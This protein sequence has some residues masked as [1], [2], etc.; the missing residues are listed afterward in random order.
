MDLIDGANYR[1][2][3]PSNRL[4][5]AG[6]IIIAITAVLAGLNIWSTRADAIAHSRQEMISLGIVLA[7]QTARSFQAVDL[8]LQ[9]TRGMV[10]AA[11]VAT[12]DQFRRLMATEEVHEYLVARLHSLP[13]ADAVTLIDDAGRIVNFSRGWPAPVLETAD[14][15]FYSYLREHDDPA[16]F[17]GLPVR[18]RVTGAWVITLTRRISGPGGEFL[19][20]VLSIIEARYFEE[21]Y[22]AITP[23]EQRSV[24]LFHRDGTVLARHPNLDAL[25]GEKISPKSPWY[26]SVA[27]GGGTYRTSSRDIGGVARIVSVQPVRE[28][29]LVIT[30]GISQETALADWRSYSVVIVIGAL[31]MAAGFA[32]LFGALARQSRR[33][34]GRTA[35][36][37]QTA[38]ALR[39]S[40]AR[41]RDYALT[42]SDWFWE[43]DEQHRFTYL[44][45]GIR[46]FGHDP[47]SLIGRSR[48]EFAADAGSDSVKWQAHFAM[49]NRHEPFRDF[50]YTRKIDGNTEYTGSVSGKPFFDA[51]GQFLGY[52]GSARDISREV[53]AERR[54]QEAKAAAESANL[55]K[56]QFLA[57][58]SHEL[59]TPLNA[60]VG[61]SEM[62]ERGLAGPLQPRQL[63]YAGLIHQSGEHLHDVINDILDLAKVDAGKLELHEEE[64]VDARRLIDDCVALLRVRADAAHVKLSVQID[65]LLPALVVD[66]TRLKQ[67]LLNLLSNAI[68]FTG[69]GGSVVVMAGR[70]KAGGID[71]KVRD[72]GPGMNAAEIAIALEPFGQ[73]DAALTRRH[74]GTGLGL[75]LARRLTEL[76]GGS[77]H[78]ASVKGR[79]T[80]ITVALPATSVM[81]QPAAWPMA[82]ARAS[83]GPAL[84]EDLSSAK[85]RRA[86]DRR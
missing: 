44:S 59:R 80:T 76:H 4:W 42:S 46:A 28:Y 61:F 73:T 16:A 66:A 22:R 45:D 1:R 24:G 67:I 70:G 9:E 57:N 38:D 39:N 6:T 18:N 19:G 17:V 41:F 51:A 26:R 36:L 71:F 2:S 20:I 14:R 30:A 84:P 23:N 3:R 11:G 74:E 50:I 21:F 10:L 47:A 55:A 62:L 52:R 43:T 63:E 12:P 5:L 69:P 64:G 35:E 68:K 33:V 65:A 82:G 75:P 37:A 72:T 83:V 78:V 53:Q 15:D 31:S 40:E 29:P 27:E 56:S 86:A 81:V 60:I 32:I 25:I 49:L 54:L 8:V 13:Q 85:R 48:V 77:L 58:M 7:E 79:G 34:E